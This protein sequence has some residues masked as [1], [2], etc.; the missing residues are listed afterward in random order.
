MTGPCPHDWSRWRSWDYDRE[1]S[2]WICAQPQ[3]RDCKRCGLT[4]R[5]RWWRA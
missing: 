3:V 2:R 5:Y 1:G 4:Q